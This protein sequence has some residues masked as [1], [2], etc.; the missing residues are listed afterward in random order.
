MDAQQHDDIDDIRIGMA[1]L[2]VH[3]RRDRSFYN[4]I[5]QSCLSC[6]F[7]FINFSRDRA[8]IALRLF[9]K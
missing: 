3:V 4:F 8:F 7:Q 6:K 2:P 9:Q 1:E 5:I